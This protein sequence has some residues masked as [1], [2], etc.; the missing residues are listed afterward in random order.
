MGIILKEVIVM[1]AEKVVR[2]ENSKV[3]EQ[4]QKYLEK[5]GYKSEETQKVY[6]SEIRAF[7]KLRNNKALEHL[8]IEDVQLTLDDFEDFVS[9]M[10]NL[11]D[12]EGNDK[13][14]NKTINKKV[15][16]VKGVIKYLASK[17]INDEYIVKDISYF[18]Q[19][20]S[21][22]ENVNHWGALEAHEVF[23]MA[24]LCLEERELGKVKRLAVLFSLDTCIR[25]GALLRLMW[26]D[27]IEKEDGVSVKWIDKGNKDFRQMI[28]KDFYNELLTI[29]GDSERVFPISDQTIDGLMSRLRL[30]MNIQAERQIVWHSI[31]KSGVTYRYR[32]TGDILEAQRAAG[33]SNVTTTQIYVEPEDYG[34]MG[35]VSS[36]GKIDMEKYR[37]VEHDVLLQAISMC[38]KDFQVI[39]N[40]KINEI[41]KEK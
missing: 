18:P 7:F 25:K 21:L 13:Y 39:L 17:K 33:H 19:I 14:S 35:A 27:F 30:K 1:L 3:Y 31:R 34:A 20:E 26:S 16:A 41:L 38:K 36:A 11:K 4:I 12:D 9:Y 8:T 32:I 2:L 40:M 29:K 23:K 22:P 6:N 5:L 24:D 15:S 10:K 28:S 37:K